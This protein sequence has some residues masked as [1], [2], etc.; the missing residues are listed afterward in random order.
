M[1]TNEPKILQLIDS[2]ATGGAERM[3]VNLANALSGVGVKSFLCA[4]RKGGALEQFINSS[5][6]KLTL[7][8]TSAIDVK[9]IY[10]LVKFIRENEINIIHAHSSSFFMAVLCKPFTGVKIVWHD[11]YGKAEQ[12]DQ[13]PMGAIRTASYFFNTVISVN[14]KL[15]F[16]SKENLHVNNEQVRFLQ[17]FAQLS[18]RNLNL[19]LPGTKKTRMVCLANLRPQ[20]DHMTLLKA[21]KRVVEKHSDWHLLLVG[22][23]SKDEY[24]DSIKRF[25]REQ[26]LEQNIHVLGSRNDTADILVNSTIGILSS[27]SEGLPVALLEYGLAKL[28]VVSTDVGQCGDVLGQGKYGEVIPVK[29]SDALAGS[30]LKL[31]EDK[32]LKNSLALKF[33]DHVLNNYSK[34]V[35]VKQLL[36]I[37]QEVLDV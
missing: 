36:D 22:Q 15:A 9:A 16:W 19:D 1:K 30:L 25:I 32:E 34:D 26:N 37:Y 4:T 21:F 33:Y 12:L 13:R 17:N 3:S 27:E 8:K 18:F 29:N 35:V 24:S 6:K 5:V 28:A 11:H 10:I 20:K 14:E 31:I 2:L 7:H 23:D